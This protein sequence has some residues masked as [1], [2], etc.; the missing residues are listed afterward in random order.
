MSIKINVSD[1]WK[2]AKTISTKVSGVWK[3]VW[4]DILNYFY[5]QTTAQSI[6]YRYF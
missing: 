3:E 6:C 4:Q 1:V 2:T 5:K